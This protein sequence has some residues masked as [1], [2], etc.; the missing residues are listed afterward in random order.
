V[1]TGWYST[2]SRSDCPTLPT[3]KGAS[4]SRNYQMHSGGFVH[5]SPS[6]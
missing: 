6:R 3:R 1:P 2:L 4:E 5:N